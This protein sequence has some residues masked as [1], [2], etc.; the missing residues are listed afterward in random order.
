[1]SV[2]IL[3][4]HSSPLYVSSNVTLSIF[5]TRCQ[6]QSEI[7]ILDHYMLVAMLNCPS[8]PLDVSSNE[9]LPFFTTRYQYQCEIAIPE[10]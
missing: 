3:N 9:K 6:Q 2:A 5:S 1:M 8:S 4:Y 10:N 7:A